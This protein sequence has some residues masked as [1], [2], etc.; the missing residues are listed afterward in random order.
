M[1]GSCVSVQGI[2]E[3]RHANGLLTVRVGDRR[4]TGR[5]ITRAPRG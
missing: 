2:L 1:M 3:T 5:P 4:Y